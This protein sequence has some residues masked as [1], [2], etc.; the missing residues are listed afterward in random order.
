MCPTIE[1]I[2]NAGPGAKAR[3]LVFDD[4]SEP[5]L[6]SAAAVKQL[7]LEA[8]VSMSRSALEETLAE[9]EFPLAKERALM[10]L[11]YRD[12]SIAELQRKLRDCGYSPSVARAVTDRMTE[13]ELL[14]DERF[15][16][17]WTRSRVSAGYGPRRIRQ[18]L[19]R[20]GIDPELA[21]AAIAESIDGEGEVARARSALRGRTAANRA[22]RDKLVRRLVSRGFSLSVA[23]A[24]IELESADQL[25]DQP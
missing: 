11:G 4:G 25:S 16:S 22:E 8:G 12:H 14:D 1:R 13:V 7:C 18:E 20:R 15:S 17:A 5:R 2:E 19:V 3:R 10:L 9:I 21:D 23:L 24:A 6:T